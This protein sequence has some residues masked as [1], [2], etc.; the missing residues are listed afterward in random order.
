[1]ARHGLLAHKAS[2]IAGDVALTDARSTFFM[3]ELELLHLRVKEIDDG[4]NI[5]ST[6]NKSTTRE[7][8]HTIHDLSAVRAKGCRKSL[9]SSK[10]K[11]IAKGNRQC[12][13]CGQNGH[14]KRMCPKRNKSSNTDI[15]P[16]DEDDDAGTQYDVRDD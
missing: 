5:G 12:R 4:G 11:S 13:I 7:D 15:D 8:S 1:M 3:D 10:E 9:K 14:D 6:R 16:Q 2:L